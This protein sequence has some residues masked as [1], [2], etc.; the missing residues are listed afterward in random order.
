MV[1]INILAVHD[2]TDRL[3][4]LILSVAIQSREQKDTS[5]LGNCID[6]QSGAQVLSLLPETLAANFNKASN[7]R[8]ENVLESK[9]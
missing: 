5:S 3:I 6:V 4:E 9:I 8:A 7:L 1:L 2:S